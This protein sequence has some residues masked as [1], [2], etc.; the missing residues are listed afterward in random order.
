VVLQKEFS[1]GHSISELGI[2]RRFFKTVILTFLVSSK[3]FVVFR[4]RKDF[5]TKNS[6]QEN[7]RTKRGT[8]RAIKKAVGISKLDSME[9]RGSSQQSTLKKKNT[10]KATAPEE[11]IK[12]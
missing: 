4:V 11:V 9:K 3:K 2:S 12:V 8:K 7:I 6:I 5:T 1:C 10:K